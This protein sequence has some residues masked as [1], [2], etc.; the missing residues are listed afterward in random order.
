MLIE[1]ILTGCRSLCGVGSTPGLHE[2]NGIIAQMRGV[3]GVAEIHLTRIE[4]TVDANYEVA[5]A[6]P[7]YLGVG[8]GEVDPI[9]ETTEGLS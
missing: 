5:F 2:R 6:T 1:T 4:G 8:M 9:E 7:T 3:G